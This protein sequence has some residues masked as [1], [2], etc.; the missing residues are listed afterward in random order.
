VRCESGQHACETLLSDNE[1]VKLERGT[2]L[3]V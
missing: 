1:H 2:H 3:A